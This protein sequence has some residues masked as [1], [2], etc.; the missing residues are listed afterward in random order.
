[1]YNMANFLRTLVLPNSIADWSL[2]SLRDRLVKIGAKAIRHA[3]SII[4][5]LAEVAVPRDLWVQM[6]STPELRPLG[7]AGFPV[8]PRR[9]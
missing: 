9:G 1:A 8:D 4:F 3:R 5:Q 7:C 2:T 6:C